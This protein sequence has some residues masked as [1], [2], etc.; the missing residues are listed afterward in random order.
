MRQ[1]CADHLFISFVFAKM[2]HFTSSSPLAYQRKS[3]YFCIVT[4][5]EKERSTHDR[6]PRQNRVR[7]TTY[8]HCLR[9]ERARL[10]CYQ[11]PD[12]P[13]LAW[14]AR[15][16]SRDLDLHKLERFLLFESQ[17]YPRCATV[18]ASL[19]K[20]SYTWNHW[21]VSLSHSSDTQTSCSAPLRG[22]LSAWHS[23]NSG[24]RQWAIGSWGV[25]TS[26]G[27]E[28]YPHLARAHIQHTA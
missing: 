9:Q 3:I 26:N 28:S 23:A 15:F 5:D 12:S 27:R 19:S 25:D 6:K 17:I 13:V 21:N 2:R 7:L 11:V 16:H 22:H 1:T 20:E 4:H 8:F 24:D 10:S 14:Y 18:W